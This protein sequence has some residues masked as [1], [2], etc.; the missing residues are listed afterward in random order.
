MAMIDKLRI[1]TRGS[2]L[3]LIQTGQV[4]KI[5]KTHHPVLNKRGAIETVVIKTTGD[6][7]QSQLLA[8]IGGKGLFTKEIDEAMLRGD[9][10]I[11][12]HSMK[13]MPTIMPSGIVLHAITER[14]DPR[15]AFISQKAKNIAELP[16]GATVGTASL[17]RK[18][19]LLNIRPDLRII[20]FRGNVDTRLK[21][22]AL[23]EADATILAYAGLKRLGKEN[24]ITDLVDTEHLLP[25]V[26]QG[27]L[28]ATCREDDKRAGMLIT[29][30]AHL[31]TIT[32]ALA[33]RTMLKALD[34]SCQTPIAGF[35]YL[36]NNKTVTLSG[37]VA[38]T[39]GIEKTEVCLNA[40]MSEAAQ[41]GMRVAEKLILDTPPSTLE[42]IKQ[43]QPAV[44]LP[45]KDTEQ[46]KYFPHNTQ[47][48]N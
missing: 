4:I 9:I 26:G 44:I 31:P 5:L 41:L 48:E 25:A 11:A 34:G 42:A 35:A 20:T 3:A 40:P 16:I 24:I 8:E 13:D 15:D 22:L 6:N 10:D 23:S 47:K 14:L 12:I 18:S 32:A 28:A 29:V 17:R 39:D 45:H 36:E 46:F 30:L 1:G 19:Q 7:E 33:E 27:T 38:Q 21:K 43:A 2:P 37:M